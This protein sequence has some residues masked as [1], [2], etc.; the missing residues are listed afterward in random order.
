MQA[1]IKITCRFLI[2]INNYCDQIWRSLLLMPTGWCWICKWPTLNFLNL[3]EI[4][5]VLADLCLFLLPLPYSLWP[6]QWFLPPCWVRSGGVIHNLVYSTGLLR[7][8]EILCIS[9]LGWC[10]F[11]SWWGLDI[12]LGWLN[13][14]GVGFNINRHLRNQWLS[15][16][17]YDRSLLS[18]LLLHHLYHHRCIFQIMVKGRCLHINIGFIVNNILILIL[19]G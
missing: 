3:I 14:D 18:H 16:A 11:L 5:L 1:L 2:R 6:L 9:T 19:M 10:R 17:G 13:R 4:G 15:L 12:E 7:S 8:S